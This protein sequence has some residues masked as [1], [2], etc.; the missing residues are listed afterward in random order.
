MCKTNKD[1][2]AAIWKQMWPAA[3]LLYLSYFLY[4][5][6]GVYTSQ[7][8]GQISDFLLY[9]DNRINDSNMLGKLI[10]AFMFTLIIMPLIDLV[11]NI[12]IFR[13]GLKYETF[14]IDKVFRKN[15]ERIQILQTNEWGGRIS[16]DPLQYRQMAVITPVRIFADV[17]VLIVAIYYL[18]KTNILLTI[19]L[20]SGMLISIMIQLLFRKRDNQ[21]REEI[22]KYQDNERTYQIEMVRSHSFWAVYRCQKSFPVK[23][24]MLFD[25]FF[26]QVKKGEIKLSAGLELF[27]KGTMIAL[28]M[29]SL[30]YGL[31]QVDRGLMTAGSFITIYFLVLQVRTMA[32]SVLTN[33]Q[34]L[35]GYDA[36]EERMKELIQGEEV[37]KEGEIEKWNNLHF[38][39]VLYYYPNTQNGMSERSFSVNHGELKEV[40]GINGSGKTTLLKLLCGVF[41]SKNQQIKLDGDCLANKNLTDWRDKIGFMQQFPDVFPGTIRENVHI[42]NLYASNQQVDWAL[43]KVNLY[44]MAER[45][46][47]GRKEELSG[48]ELK[49]IEL[50]RVLLRME[51]TEIIMLDEPYENLDE[52]GRKIV[53]EILDCTE[54]TRILITHN[55]NGKEYGV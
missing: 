52:E 47:Q 10:I 14:V 41:L 45:Q 30:F 15:Y 18:L 28:F 26:N 39:N 33:L 42:G 11:T 37:K 29:V 44:E 51:Q 50:A 21:F 55:K 3:L 32:E 7:I 1:L 53:Q 40:E 36:Q 9:R 13:K 49:R 23:M 22:R 4:R 46:L 12:F 6:I 27:Q 24:N 25:S 8:L 17:T 5:W 38:E 16:R 2:M 43:Q 34:T 31:T 19:I 48:G 54:K 20:T 35:R